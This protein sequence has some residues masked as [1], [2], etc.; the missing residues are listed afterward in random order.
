MEDTNTI[1]RTYMAADATLIAAV[2]AKI[3]CPRLPH[4]ASIPAIA[5]KRRGGE[6]N[7]H[8][9]PIVD[10][11]YQFICYGKDAEAA[12]AV[13]IALYDALQ[14]IQN[15]SVVVG[16]NTYRIMR[17]MAEGLGQPFEDEEIP[18]YMGVVGFFKIM[19]Q[20]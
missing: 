14:G 8:I 9:P 5:F 15:Q 13:Y 4:N 19:I 12:E 10:P 3:Y 11:S 16:L 1:L 18:N 17:A 20:T 2:G 7:P 6:C